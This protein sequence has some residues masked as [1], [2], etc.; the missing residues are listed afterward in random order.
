MSE[1]LPIIQ[2]LVLS[3]VLG[4]LV[5]L[6]REKQT[7]GKNKIYFGGIRTFPIIAML[8]NIAAQFSK[9]YSNVSILLAVFLVLCGLIG[10]S[11]IYSTFK[12]NRAGLTSELSGITTFFIG[13]S[14]IYLPQIYPILTTIMLVLL[15][16][17]KKTL[18]Q[19]SQKILQ[20]ELF[21]VIKFVI[22][23][24]II[25]PLLPN[26]TIDPW[27]LFNPYK[28]WLIA[29]IVSA[30]SFAGYVS[31]KVI[32]PKKGIYTTGLIG[33]IYSSTNVN[34]VF[35]KGSKE[36]KIMK[37]EYR[38]GALLSYVTS[39]IKVG[40]LIYVLNKALFFKVLPPLVTVIGT[41]ALLSAFLMYT[42][43]KSNRSYQKIHL[44]NPFTIVFALEFALFL[45]VIFA[46]ANF[47]YKYLGNS[48]I[49]LT[50]LI[51][52]LA[53]I[54]AIT[55]AMSELAGK[56]VEG[57][58]VSYDSAARAIMIGILFSAISKSVYSAL[59]GTFEYA[60]ALAP[61]MIMAGLSGLL[62]SFVI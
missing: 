58:L 46:V 45:S 1:I 30:I 11:Y 39:V 48:G 13:I 31:I 9:L 47:A 16:T 43:A 7:K 33:G 50:S 21:A 19:F 24:F 8:G 6:E 40:F 41:G 22:I 52:G 2:K 60:K 17:L 55:V 12:H 18:H 62:I 36:N 27:N 37:Y 5:G 23:T 42:T 51:S 14:T 57:N 49:Y 38:N 4:L 26:H 34:L 10:I 59:A 35:A 61:Y 53:K 44:K 20:E 54:D 3:V 29:V 25:L 32:G 28:T 15:L 56:T